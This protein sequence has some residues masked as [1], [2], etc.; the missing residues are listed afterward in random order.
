[1]NK[2]EDRRFGSHEGNHKKATGSLMKRVPAL[3]AL[4]FLILTFGG[5]VRS[6][7]LKRALADADA[8][9]TEAAKTEK[10]NKAHLKEI[11]S[12]K[13]DVT[14]LRS[15]NESL[16]E[17]ELRN[18]DLI[19]SLEMSLKKKINENNRLKKKLD[20]QPE[21]RPAQAGKRAY[22]SGKDRDREVYA[23]IY[24]VLKDDIAMGSVRVLQGDGTLSIF[25]SGRHLFKPETATLL[26]GG[27][28]ILQRISSAR[29]HLGA[30]EARIK[31]CPVAKAQDF[32][33][34]GPDKGL[35]K[36][37]GLA[38]RR[39]IVVTRFLNER[40]GLGGKTGRSLPYRGAPGATHAGDIEIVLPK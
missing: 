31:V 37:R 2:L 23:E 34:L 39:V 16:V 27:K 8:A 6:S 17:R 30:R 21:L 38:A 13:K 24:S 4:L 7:T 29:G 22:V 40:T 20:S 36:D 28:A 1:M 26:A 14:E 3:L 9:R 33:V 5:C 15:R 19:S 25:I 32:Q 10:A 11:A 18:S 35:E 12:L